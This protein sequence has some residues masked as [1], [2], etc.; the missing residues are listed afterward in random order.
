MRFLIAFVLAL[1]FGYESV[2]ADPPLVVENKTRIV[3]K[4]HTVAKSCPCG[5]TCACEAGVCP[6]CPA[7][8][9]APVRYVQVCGPTG[10]RLVPVGSTPPATTPAAAVAC[11]TGTCGTTTARTG[12]YPGKR[13]GRIR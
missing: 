1:V 7:T 4:N 6:A 10:C 2:A 8:A 5:A 11:A 9:A 13:L 3:V 12:W